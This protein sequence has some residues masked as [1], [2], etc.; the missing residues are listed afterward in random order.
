[1]PE[2]LVPPTEDDGGSGRHAEGLASPLNGGTVGVIVEE[3]GEGRVASCAVH[4]CLPLF[5][6]TASAQ[7]LLGDGGGG[8]QDGGDVVVENLRSG[9]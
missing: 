2:L 9:Q 4:L 5:G 7:L 3:E 8:V 6:G 1:M